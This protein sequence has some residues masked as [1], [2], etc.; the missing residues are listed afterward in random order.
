MNQKKVKALRRA[1]KQNGVT[2]TER[3]YDEGR[4]SIKTLAD[5]KRYAV[6]GTITLSP[7]C[8]RAM[9]KRLKNA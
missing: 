6:T 1:L 2:A 4:G 8:G 9:Y 5:G 3:S 7:Q